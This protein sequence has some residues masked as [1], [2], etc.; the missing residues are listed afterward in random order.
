MARTIGRRTIFFAVTS[1][2][3]VL[4]VPAMPPEFRW[5]A[6]FAAGLGAFWA[7][8]LALEDLS[9]PGTPRPRTTPPVIPPAPFQ[10]PPPPGASG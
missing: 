4:L 8:A 2:I 5:V 9:A 6:W 10:P 1:L 3:C 7:V